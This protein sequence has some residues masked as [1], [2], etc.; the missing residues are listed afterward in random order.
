M[1]SWLEKERDRLPLWLPVGFGAGIAIWEGYWDGAYIAVAMISCALLLS[2]WLVAK[3]SRLQIV[4]ISAALTIAAGYAVISAKSNWVAAPILQKISITRFYARIEKVDM[5]PAR[6]VIRLQL[7]TDGHAGLPRRIRVNLDTKQY[8]PEFAVGA[9]I[10]LRARLMPPA[11]PMLPGG[12]DFARRVWFSGIGATGTALGDVTL[13]RKSNGA[14]QLSSVR[15]SLTGHI[16]DRMSPSSGGIGAA[17]ITGDTGGIDPE[18][19]QVMRDSGMAH[20]LSIS[21]LHVTAVVGAVFFLSS[22]ILSLFPLFALRF[23]VPLVSAAL[24]ALAAIGYTLISGS[25]VPTVRSCIASLLVLAAMA[26]GREALSLRLVAFGALFVLIFWPESMAGPSFQLSFAAVTTIV[27]LHELPIMRRIF[28]DQERGWTMRILF[29]LASLL[30]TGIAI[31]LALAPITL[32]HF[33]RSGLYGALANIVAIPLT[34]FI[35]MPCEGLALL[36]DSIGLGQP[37]WWL[38]QWGVDALIWIARYI[39]ALPGAV[40]SLPNMPNWAYALMVI[41]GLWAVI[42][43]TKW[44]IFGILPFVIGFVA[45]LLV[46]RPDILITGDGKHVALINDDGTMAILRARAGD[47]VK[48]ALGETAGISTE[49]MAIEQWAG[50]NCTD[51]SCVFGVNSEGRNWRILATRSRYAIPTMELSAACRRVDIVISERWLPYSC[52]PRWLKLDRN[53]LANSGGVAI[54]F[55]NNTIT[56]VSQTNKGSPWQYA[57]AVANQKNE[58]ARHDKMAKDLA[59]KTAKSGKLK[60]DDITGNSIKWRSNERAE[61]QPTKGQR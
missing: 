40:S 56:T 6:D 11:P 15:S 13:Y 42:F 43:Q 35:I 49:P 18:V 48:D 58:T 39:S 55:S 22:R 4:L 59:D 3:G 33:N 8:R 27:V 36:F 57:Q 7:A 50:A 20:L 1:E 24:G 61:Q 17:L 41:G 52:K 9:V 44:R 14:G 21:G 25:E 53:F 10:D 2:G 30:L 31:E 19:A 32:A 28:I 5:L 16:R 54:N 29:G 38:A 26:M 12:Y 23:A 51:D 46:P 37:F 45:M 47:Y 60:Q 34:T